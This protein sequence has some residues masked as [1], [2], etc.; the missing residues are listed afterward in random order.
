M[1]MMFMQDALRHLYGALRLARFDRRGLDHIDGSAEGAI[2]SFRA[3][4]FVLPGY[5]VLAAFDLAGPLAE[6]STGRFI[7]VFSI[8]YALEWTAFPLVMAWI[9]P[10]IG[11]DARYTRYVAALNWAR[12]IQMA[13]FLPALLLVF[14]APDSGLAVLVLFVV[15]ALIAYHWFVAREALEI[16]GGQAAGIVALNMGLS[17]AISL[18]A[19]AIAAGGAAS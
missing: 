4:L 8:A 16:R 11:A 18:W 13:V 7:L 6:T 14:L 10:L 2:R 1:A 12:V 19:H 9:T 17:G 15:V 3:A 5:A